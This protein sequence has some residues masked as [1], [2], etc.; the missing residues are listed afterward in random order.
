MRYFF[1]LINLL[2]ISCYGDDEQLSP[3]DQLPLATQTGENIVACLIDGEPWVNDP[4]RTGE[5]NISASYYTLHELVW[6]R[7]GG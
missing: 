3:A 6:A 2:T 5:V 7:P 1:L 4:N